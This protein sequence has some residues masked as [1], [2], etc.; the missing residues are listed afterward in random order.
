MLY[1]VPSKNICYTSKYSYKVVFL[2]HCFLL[3]T[4]FRGKTEEKNPLK[5]HFQIS[6]CDT[7]F[8]IHF[9][10]ALVTKNVW[11]ILDFFIQTGLFNALY[12][13]Q[14]IKKN[15]KKILKFL[16]VKS[17]KNFKVIGQKI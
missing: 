5:C 4:V 11:D 7:C 2:F 15:Y 12:P 17:H 14:G 6:K 3:I 8:Y 10:R 16:L 13:T 9:S 1:Y